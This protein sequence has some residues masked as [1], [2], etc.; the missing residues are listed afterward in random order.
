MMIIRQDNLRPIAKK[1][2]A[3]KLSVIKKSAFATSLAS[4]QPSVKRQR[5]AATEER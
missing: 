3:L 2:L 1:Q 4:Q 5:R